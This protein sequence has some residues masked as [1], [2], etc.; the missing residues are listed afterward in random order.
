MKETVAIV[1]GAGPAGIST[2][3]CLNLQS[4]PH[5]LL[6]REDCYCPIWKKKAYD[7][8]HLHLPK[9]YCE[10]PHMSFPESYP[11]F[12]PRKQFVQYL[13]EYVSNFK[14]NPACNRIIELATYD[15]VEKKWCVK[16]RHTKTD[17]IEDFRAKFLIVAT[18]ENSE[19]FIPEMKGLESFKGEILH[20]TQYK[21]G[22]KYNNKNVLVVGCGDSGMEIACDLANFGAKTSVVIRSPLHVLTRWMVQFTLFLWKYLPLHWV[23]SLI[24]VLSML[25]FGDMSKYGITRP[26]E[27][28]YY[29]KDKYGKYPNIDA[30][31]IKKIKAGEIQ[32]LPGITSINGDEVSFTNG[33][34]Y[35]FDVILFATG[36]R[37]TTKKW[38][39]GDDYLLGDDGIAK[40]SFPNHWKG[41]KG[42]YCAGL[43]RAGLRGAGMDAQS[44][45]N[46]IK[47]LK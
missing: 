22:S 11:K 30:G 39:K 1:V 16:V 33:K 35:H 8:L 10:L 26:N 37:R 42:L 19:P 4:I 14:V 44:I 24:V 21:S 47:T 13:D 43:G 12:V 38:L 7:R 9:Q 40:Q 29:M 2:S 20:S 3:A 34:S 27:G 15:E 5:I 32:V 36:F 46:D 45:A 17:E 28:P 31:A 25:W 23:D 41:K 18:G 6:E